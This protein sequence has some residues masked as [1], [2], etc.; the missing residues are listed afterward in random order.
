MVQEI[1]IG[2]KLVSFIFCISNDTMWQKSVEYIKKIIIP[3][4]YS[5][6]II[7]IISSQK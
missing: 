7:E 2:N 5:I 3:E 6:E 1:L 4:G